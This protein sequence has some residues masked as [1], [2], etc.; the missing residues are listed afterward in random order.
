MVFDNEGQRA[1]IL[2]LLDAVT[3]SGKSLDALFEFKTQVR[4]AEIATEVVDA[5]YNK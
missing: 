3:V 4:A 2:E 1:I 5:A